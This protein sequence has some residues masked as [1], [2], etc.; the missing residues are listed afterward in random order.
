MK[1]KLTILL[2]LMLI[3]ATVTAH[4][5]KKA[6]EKQWTLQNDEVYQQEVSVRIPTDKP[7]VSIAEDGDNSYALTDEK[8]YR[9]ENETLKPENIAPSGISVLTSENADY[10]LRHCGIMDRGLNGLEALSYMEAAIAATGEYKFKDC[11]QQLI[12]WGHPSNTIRQAFFTI[13]EL[14]ATTDL[15]KRPKQ[16]TQNC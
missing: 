5:P 14:G 1:R 10:L 12:K 7:V 13:T 9:I 16:T 6:N 8:L 2:V 3:V 15:L 4:Y 11:C